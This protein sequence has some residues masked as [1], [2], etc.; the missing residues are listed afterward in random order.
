MSF[1]AVATYTTDKSADM[2]GQSGFQ[3]LG[4]D[5]FD[6][7]ITYS[8]EDEAYSILPN[9]TYLENISDSHSGDLSLSSTDNEGKLFSYN[10][11]RGEAWPHSNSAASLPSMPG[12]QFYSELS[13]R[14]AI[15]DSELLSLENIN[16]ES[17]LLPAFTQIS[18]PPSPSPIAS[19]AT[20]RKNRI[21]ESLSKTFKRATANLDTRLLRSPIRKSSSS[22]K[23]IRAHSNKSSTDLWGDK[24][25][26]LQL[27]NFDFETQ[28]N[29]LPVSPPASAKL[30]VFKQEELTTPSKGKHNSVSYRNASNQHANTSSLYD[31]PLATPKLE[32][33]TSRN[34]SRRI[35]ADLYPITPQA[36]NAGPTWPQLPNT[37]RFTSLD[38]NTMYPDLESPLWYGHANTA[39]LA[40]P[41]PSG[42]HT[43]PQRATK[44]LAMQ[45]QNDL[46]F[47]TN[48]LTLDP[49]SGLGIQ[50]P[51]SNMTG[52]SFIMG[53]PPVMHNNQQGYYATP[54]YG[55]QPQQAQ[56]HG[57]HQRHQSL[58]QNQMPGN[59]QQMGHRRH[60]SQNQNQ[61]PGQSQSPIRKSQRPTSR[62]SSS[63]PSLSPTAHLPNFSIRKRKNQNRE[64]KSSAS[65]TPTGAAV[66]VD[67]VNYTPSDSRKILT[68]V[69]PSGSSKTKARREKEA[70]EKRRKLSQAAV[71]AVR[72]AGGDLECLEGYIVE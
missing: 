68:G 31:T 23:M 70:A 24:L 54:K 57:H 13:G 4:S 50:M 64:K 15:S 32:A 65:R 14:A 63:S 29:I 40:Q 12:S 71:R 42:F 51:I 3:D 43:S 21:A 46:A 16:L 37:Q 67:F 5:F 17:P 35:P 9:S 34:V 61:M 55:N 56:P 45:L 44:S 27:S 19:A 41:S 72:A 7:F 39:P 49:L 58:N 53:S 8:P 22:P 59:R 69:A 11:W 2:F 66:I 1:S 25:D 33:P 30:P 38:T 48:D 62:N 18:L 26:K 10:P 52:Q 60:Q 36:Q 28:A 20:R 6:Q 47:S